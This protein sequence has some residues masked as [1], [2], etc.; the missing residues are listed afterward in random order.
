MLKRQFKPFQNKYLFHCMIISVIHDIGG[1]TNQT[2]GWGLIQALKWIEYCSQGGFDTHFLKYISKPEY[3]WLV[4][5]Y[6]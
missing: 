3:S 1:E 4:I 2:G 6:K 5:S